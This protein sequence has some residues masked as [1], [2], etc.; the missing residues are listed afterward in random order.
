MK[1]KAID[2]MGIILF[3]I[4]ALFLFVAFF[5]YPIGFVVVTSF[6]KWDGMSKA[7]FDGFQNY[8]NILGDNIFISSIK[9][10]IIWAF[11]GGFIQVPLAILVALLLAKKPKGWKFLRTVYF[12]PNIISTLALAMM[13]I[14]IFNS[15]YGIL[16]AFL[17]LI[18]LGSLQKN[19]LGDMN[20]AFPVMI[21][22]WLCYIGYF[23]VI[24][25]ADISSI[26]KSFYE[27]AEID[28]ASKI[29]QD[30]YITLPLIKGSI[31]TCTTLAMVLGLRQFEQ[32]YLM[33]NGGPDNKTSVMGLY[34]FK[35]LQNF[36]YGAANAT[37]VILILIGTIM[38]I[39]L[40]KL[41]KV[42]RY[43]M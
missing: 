29:K 26:P 8:K 33:T 12:F 15:D 31:A 10:N 22:Y 9:N 40:K 39:S 30:I 23:M 32:V 6:M 43:E 3:L 34:L 16:N 42:D 24:I 1:S 20:T 41:Y 27:A 35:G 37:G 14:A 5:I 25:L 7:V 13:W 11:A 17:K 18:G 38:I 19:W 28:G 2:K 21:I 36:D 4:P